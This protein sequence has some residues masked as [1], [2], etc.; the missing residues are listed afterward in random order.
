MPA[1][2]RTLPNRIRRFIVITRTPRAVTCV[3]METYK[4]VTKPQG[5]SLCK[6]NCHVPHA[7]SYRGVITPHSTSQTQWV[8]CISSSWCYVHL[9]HRCAGRGYW[10]CWGEI[11]IHQG[12]CC[13]LLC[14]PESPTRDSVCQSAIGPLSILW[15]Q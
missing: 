3:A 9:V 14:I 10:A 2:P 12:H 11:F 5:S 4:N 6:Q 1:Y 13:V 7:C 15:L 8:H